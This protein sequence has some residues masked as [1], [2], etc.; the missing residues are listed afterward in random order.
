[1]PQLPQALVTGLTVGL[2]AVQLHC[3]FT[4]I[5]PAL[6]VPFVYFHFVEVWAQHA[7]EPL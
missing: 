6:S 2:V 1:L 4:S 7:G 3:L 5:K